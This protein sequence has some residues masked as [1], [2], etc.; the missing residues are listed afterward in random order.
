[1]VVNARKDEHQ[2]DAHREPA[3]LLIMHAG[4]GTAVRGGVNLQH[5][6]GANRRDDG[7]QP[8]IVI[9]SAWCVSHW[10][11]RAGSGCTVCSS[12]FKTAVRGASAAAGVFFFGAGLGGFT[13][14]A[15]T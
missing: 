14:S 8:P 5:A 12:S 6:Q 7:E 10:S 3:Q 9:A 1:M 11:S 13:F 2:D 15:V 4:K